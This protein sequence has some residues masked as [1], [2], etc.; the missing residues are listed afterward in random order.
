MKSR[1]SIYIKRNEKLL[2]FQ[3]SFNKYYVPFRCQGGS[4]GSPKIAHFKGA[5]KEGP[6]MFSNR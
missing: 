1:Q 2:K 6:I 5:S 3:A 4:K